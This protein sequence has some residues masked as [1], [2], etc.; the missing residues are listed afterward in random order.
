M[1]HMPPVKK[2]LYPCCT[3]LLLTLVACEQ[4]KP[5]ITDMDNAARSL[6]SARAAGAATYAPLEIRF[7][8]ERLNQ[9]RIAMDKHDFVA[10]Q[11]VAEESS[12]TSDLA[13]TK[14]RLAKVREQVEARS[15]ENTHLR[16]DLL[17]PTTTE[18]APQQ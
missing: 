3:F 6:Q 5:P 9:A 2:I 15:R 17:A 16:E 7:A 4:T 11:R 8:E 10:A 1:K 18:E 12:V 13:R 14:V